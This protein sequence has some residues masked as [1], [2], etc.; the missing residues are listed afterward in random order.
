MR[1]GN[2]IVGE[3]KCDECGKVNE[4][5]YIIA[6]N[7]NSGKFHVSVID[8]TKAGAALIRGT[9]EK[10]EEFKIHCLECDK[11]IFIEYIED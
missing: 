3:Q 1:K 10:P 4:W 6:D 7:I 5:Y 9:R 8:R 2:Q 11:P